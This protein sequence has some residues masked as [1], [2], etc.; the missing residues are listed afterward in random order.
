MLLPGE[1]NWVPLRELRTMARLVILYRTSPAGERGRSVG[2]RGGDAVT[3]RARR[4]HCWVIA[5][6]ISV[7]GATPI[8]P[9][10]AAA[11][12]APL[13]AGTFGNK[14][15]AAPARF[16]PREG[17]ARGEVA[18]CGEA[19]GDTTGAGMWAR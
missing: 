18:C 7:A 3:Q 6:E 8:V 4:M 15:R 14:G 11:A 13:D 5:D 19:D 17:D 2:R 1:W 10:G 9:T 16:L 12:E